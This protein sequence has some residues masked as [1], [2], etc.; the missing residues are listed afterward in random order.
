M[1]K[2]QKEYE[3]TRNKY[4]EDH[5]QKRFLEILERFETS[6][7]RDT[8]LLYVALA[9]GARA[10]EVLNITWDDLD[11]DRGTI[12]IKGIKDSRDR[13]MPVSKEIFKKVSSL[14]PD[15]ITKK[16][17]KISYQRFYQIW[18]EYRPVKKKLHSLRHTFAINVYRGTKSLYILQT[19]LGHKSLSN[20]MI[21]SKYQARTEELREAISTLRLSSKEFGV[22]S[23]RS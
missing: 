22:D 17:F 14:V 23:D 11:F 12:F 19:A 4:L 1:K 13:E 2:P 21:Y 6:N 7:P 8:A 20:T 10:T 15:P 9:T 16:I 18:N 5:E 3:L